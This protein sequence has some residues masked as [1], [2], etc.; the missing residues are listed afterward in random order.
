MDETNSSVI[1]FVVISTLTLIIL[2]GLVIN[3]LLLSRNRRLQHQTKVYEINSNFEKELLSAKYEIKGQ[4][5]DQIAKD[6]HNDVGQLLTSAL[7]QLNLSKLKSNI[8]DIYLE[9]AHKQVT[10]SLN[11]VRDFSKLISSEFVETRGLKVMLERLIESIKKN[12][13]EILFNFNTISNDASHSFDL[14][15]YRV[16]QEFLTNTLKHAKASF[17]EIHI[18]ITGEKV[19]VVY[20]D[21]GIWDTKNN[22]WKPD[23]GIGLLSIKNRIELLKGNFVLQTNSPS[24]FKSVIILPMLKTSKI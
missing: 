18:S 6:L 17:V 22:S 15:I 20:S 14:I 7:I 19:M 21:N 16:I 4:T 8:Q 23:S 1:F 12:G 11:I 9:E 10:E 13:I 5:Q 3:L 24:G 2:V